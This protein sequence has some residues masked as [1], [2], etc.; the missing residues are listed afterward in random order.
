MAIICDAPF[1][2]C[3]VFTSVS[4][5]HIHTYDAYR[6]IDPPHEVFHAMERIRTFVSKAAE[7]EGTNMYRI[8]H[9]YIHTYT[10][11]YI[12]YILYTRTTVATS[13]G[14]SCI[15]AIIDSYVIHTYIYSSQ[16]EVCLTNTHTYIHIQYIKTH[17]VI[18]D[19]REIYERYFPDNIRW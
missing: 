17:H 10:H 8:T 12:Q 19:N 2:K 5:T 7:S 15:L 9:T 6:F 13:T 3:T 11:A 14:S 4:H 16:I 1:Y 18:N